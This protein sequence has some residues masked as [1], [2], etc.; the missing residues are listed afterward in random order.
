LSNVCYN[1]NLE[2]VRERALLDVINNY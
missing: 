2:E 1:K